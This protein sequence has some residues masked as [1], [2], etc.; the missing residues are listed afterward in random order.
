MAAVY[1]VLSER[2][3]KI[4]RNDSLRVSPRALTW[5]RNARKGSL[6]WYFS[7]PLVFLGDLN[8][9]WVS[10][11]TMA[12]LSSGPCYGTL[13][14]GI[15]LVHLSLDWRETVVHSGLFFAC[16]HICDS[17]LIASFVFLL[18]L[19]SDFS[20]SSLQG[21]GGWISKYHL[22]VPPPL[23]SWFV[24]LFLPTQTQTGRQITQMHVHTYV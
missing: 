1:W 12:I 23:P 24:T 4:F 16:Y 6:G 8:W 19:S 3:G 17:P 2:A 21:L 20:F 15:V 10:G 13:V 22:L 7:F 14:L 11:P 9:A 5:G 18:S